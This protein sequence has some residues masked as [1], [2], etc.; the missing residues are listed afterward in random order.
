MD[1]L[2]FYNSEK[3][4]KVINI[5]RG[6]IKK[7]DI[8][9]ATQL[10]TPDWI[11]KYMVDNSLGKY[12][13]ERNQN[14][15]LNNYLEFYLDEAE[16]SNDV[17]D[18][19][20]ETRRN[21]I[22]IN[23]V[24]FFDPCMGSAHILVYAFDIF[25]EIYKELGYIDNEIPELI[26]KN[27]LYGLDIDKRAYQLSYFAIMMKSR[28]YD[29]KI[30]KK[31]IKPDVFE[32]REP[33]N[34]PENLLTEIKE[35]DEEL[36]ESLKYLINVFDNAKEFGSLIQIE[37]INFEKI[38]IS[39]NEF[40][41]SMKRNLQTEH[42]KNIIKNEIFPLVYQ[43][44]ILAQKYDIVVTN[45]PYMNKFDKTLKEF[46][47]KYYKDYSK[48]LFSMFIYRNFD[49]CKENGYSALMTPFVWMFI[50]SYE[51]L[52]KYI[53][54]NK[55]I[56]S[57]IQL[58]Y[59]AFKEATVPIC[60][61]V[62]CNNYNKNYKGTYLKL[63]EFTG[64]MEVQK[65]KV[66]E[67]IDN[68]VLFNDK[69]KFYH[70]SSKFNQ[71]PGSPIIYSEGEKLNNIFKNKKLGDIGYAKR[72]L[73]TGNNKRFLRMWFEVN[74]KK[75]NFKCNSCEE[76]V[77]K[78]FKWF[79]TNKGGKYRKWYG[80]QY[81]IVNW[82]N[83]GFELRN[84]RDKKGKR[85]SAISNS[86]FYF[87]K[88]ISWSMVSSGNI[89]FRYFPKG[90]IFDNAGPC[91]FIDEKKFNYM[92]GFLN[93]TVCNYIIK[94]IAPTLAYEVGDVSSLPIIFSKD[95]LEEIDKLVKI[96]IKICKDDWDS[97]E[98]SWNFS[99]HPLL[100]YKCNLIENSF[101][102]WTIYKKEQFNKL[103]SSENKLNEIFAT[104]YDVDIDCN[105][106]DKY[107]SVSLA[108]YKSNIKSFISYAVGCMFGRYSLG[109]EGLI[110]A[111]GEFD[112]DKYHKFIPDNDNIIPI[113]DTEYF[114]DDI[115]G[116]FV[117]FVKICFGE[118]TLEENLD[119]IAG[120]LNK[121]G[122]SSREI[123]R[124]YFLKDFFKDHVKTYQK[125][126]IYW[127]FDSGKQDGFK[128]LIYMQRYD[129]GLVARVRTDY[130]HKTQKAIEEN[131]NN[132]NNIIEN[133]EIKSEIKKAEKSKNKL[134]KQLE[135]IKQYDEIL[136]HVANQKIEIDLDEG[137][138]TNYKKFQNIKQVNQNNDK[139]T[140]LLKRI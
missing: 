27:N 1:Y 62:F 12:W 115:V 77:E 135:E 40:I 34:I 3:K 46:S 82:E 125:C 140:N 81:Y 56:S 98:T 47:K 96:N 31:G 131:L 26:I 14:T 80:N 64:G 121:K 15:N 129:S 83:N 107:V 59:S 122:K 49:F 30:F 117:E 79:P 51:K 106:E 16:Q 11:V 4:D 60:T 7:Q 54:N 73:M 48:D 63:S 133:S 28:K 116:R 105:V 113:L 43:G 128:C 88:Q 93:S 19:F 8:P 44:E 134:I 36:F 67:I 123:I 37:N 75:I 139:K 5:K 91:V 99:N 39:L 110:F 118:E 13:I 71:I 22:K 10:F 104:I 18:F 55:N 50:S 84:Y 124:N 25:F 45:P 119:F 38:K 87:H 2:Y 136:T 74:Y 97:Y 103:K 32:I 42:Y 137:I 20:K 127:Q 24:K 130:L 120:A 92:L 68:P 102:E 9:A 108:D 100:K 53:I 72:G 101:K 41:N 111:G 35:S 114:E 65:N 138:K 95:K 86:K 23:E 85:K 126:P 61:F 17:Y 70:K 132:C 76:S 33:N 109:E 29:R 69:N 90:F 57:L 94:L 52:R 89:S 66:L 58:E 112:L 21:N 78:N 6:N